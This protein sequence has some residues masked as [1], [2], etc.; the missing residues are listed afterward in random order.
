MNNKVIISKSYK[1][2]VNLKMIGESF[3]RVEFSTFMNKEIED[4]EESNIIEQMRNMTDIVV[5]ETEKDI[6]EGLYH[7]MDLYRDKDN[8]AL[9]G[10]GSNFK[11]YYKERGI[12]ND[13]KLDLKSDDDDYIDIDS[14]L[15]SSKVI[16]DKTEIKNKTDKTKEKEVEETEGI[17]NIE[18]LEDFNIDD[19]Q[20]I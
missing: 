20:D 14:L 16:E 5:Q 10:T 4:E 8:N 2:S 1:R 7:I 19:Y 17:E 18:G 13:K 15:D 6:K 12:D 9:V 11:D 3:D